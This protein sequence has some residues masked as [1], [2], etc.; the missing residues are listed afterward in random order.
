MNV[1]SYGIRMWRKFRSFCHNACVWQTDGWTVQWRHTVERFAVKDRLVDVHLL[2]MCVSFVYKDHWVQVKVT[3]AKKA[4]LFI[5]YAGCLLLTKR[6]SCFTDWTNGWS[7]CLSAHHL[8]HVLFSCLGV[9][10]YAGLCLLWTAS[11]TRHHL[12][13]IQ[14]IIIII[15]IIIIIRFVK[16]QNVK[17]LPWR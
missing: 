11:A 1:L 16:R 9:G 5:L 10:D 12:R 2:K 8:P 15:I 4:C 13:T 17:R 14:T 3:G 6:Q 7:L